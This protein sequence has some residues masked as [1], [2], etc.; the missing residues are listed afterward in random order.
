MPLLILYHTAEG[1]VL[2]RETVSEA[3][4]E[5]LLKDCLAHE[6]R[7]VA[8]RQ[9]ELRALRLGRPDGSGD[10]PVGVLVLDHGYASSDGCE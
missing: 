6:I 5:L 7:L 8:G 9:L 3:G 1:L 4:R 2:A 10:T